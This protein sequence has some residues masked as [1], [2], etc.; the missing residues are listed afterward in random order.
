MNSQLRE[1]IIRAGEL[2]QEPREVGES[3]NIWPHNFTL[4]VLYMEGQ[5]IVRLMHNLGREVVLSP[6]RVI[7]HDESPHE[8]L[9][10]PEGNF[11]LG[12]VFPVNGRHWFEVFVPEE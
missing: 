5:V 6:V 9:L 1:V 7:I 8:G 10:R 11:S 12:G 4:H 3:L 2:L